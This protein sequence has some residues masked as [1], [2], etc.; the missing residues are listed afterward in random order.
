MHQNSIQEREP[1]SPTLV[2]GRNLER[3]DDM[4]SRR[5]LAGALSVLVLVNIFNLVDRTILGVVGQ[6]MKVDL[7]LRD[8]ELGLLSGPA[9]GLVYAFS[10]LAMAYLAERHAR[11][12]IVGACLALWSG[13]T[14]LCGLAQGFWGM[15]L[16]RMGVG[17]G[18]AGCAPASQSLISDY[19]PPQRRATAISIHALGIPVGVLVGAALCGWLAT[20]Y[21]WRTAFMCVGVPGVLVAFVVKFVLREPP[22]GYS[23]ALAGLHN[24]LQTAPSMSHVARTLWSRHAFR[25]ILVG[26]ALMSFTGYG[27]VTFLSPFFVRG[28]GFSYAQAGLALALAVAVPSLLAVPAGGLL[29]DWANRYDRRSYAWIPALGMIICAPIAIA[30]YAQA[31][32]TATIAALVVAGFFNNLYHGPTTAMVLNMVESRMRASAS[33]L[34]G[35][36][37]NVVGVGLGPPAFGV[38]IDAIS[39]Q[40]FA[41]RGLGEFA[42]QCPGGVASANAGARVVDACADSIAIG[43]RQTLTMSCILLLWAAFHYL[44]AA[45][46]IR[47]DMRH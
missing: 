9:F 4:F 47:S 44:R 3:R 18:E 20:T 27:L 25:H 15:F 16:C 45:R 23:D 7:G 30:G 1:N 21:G 32:A 29:V 8:F 11:V 38:A 42:T 14:A 36:V 33:A 34:H 12:T 31:S 13:M 41:Q 6:A 46:T 24:A 10:A 5:Y 22:R 35:F 43:T 28:Y 40:A 37:A 17:I 26:T 39:A 2:D 19:F